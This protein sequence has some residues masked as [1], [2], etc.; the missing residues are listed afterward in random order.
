MLGKV[1]KVGL[2]PTIFVIL[3]ILTNYD[4]SNLYFE[5]KIPILL[6]NIRFYR[7]GNYL[8]IMSISIYD[9]FLI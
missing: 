1:R 9:Y 5:F 8:A 7:N 4:C 2:E 3:L 6:I